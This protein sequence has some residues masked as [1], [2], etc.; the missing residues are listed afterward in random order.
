MLV[1]GF[2]AVVVAASLP[3]LSVLPAAVVAVVIASC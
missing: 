3:S 2:L 1:A